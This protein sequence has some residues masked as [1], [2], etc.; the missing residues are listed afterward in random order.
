MMQPEQ[1]RTS[2]QSSPGPVFL[3]LL[4][5]TDIL[6]DNLPRG[7]CG[8]ADGPLS[9]CL[10]M[11]T[12]V[13]APTSNDHSSLDRTA[14]RLQAANV[15]SLLAKTVLRNGRVSLWHISTG[16]TTFNSLALCVHN[17]AKMM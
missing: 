14:S 6:P 7:F 13:F 11:E 8:A 16:S 15:A 9:G 2:R 10:G 17:A 5:R 4:F 12:S 3:G 1:E